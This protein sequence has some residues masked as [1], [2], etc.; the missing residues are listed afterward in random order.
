MECISDINSYREHDF[1]KITLDRR[2]IIAR[3]A[4]EEF[5]KGVYLSGLRYCDYFIEEVNKQYFTWFLNG[6][7]KREEKLA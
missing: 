6:Q 2:E 3:E 7:H 4:N 1:A 5:T